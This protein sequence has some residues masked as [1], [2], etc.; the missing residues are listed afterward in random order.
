M[1]NRINAQNVGTSQPSQTDQTPDKSSID[2]PFRASAP[3]LYAVGYCAL[4]VAYRGKVPA[5]ATGVIVNEADREAKAKYYPQLAESF[6][7]GERAPKPLK[8][9]QQT[10]FEELS[11]SGAIRAS[12]SVSMNVGLRLGPQGDDDQTHLFAFDLDTTDPAIIS[13]VA[14]ALDSVDGPIIRK[15]AH[16]GFTQF[17]RIDPAYAAALPAKLRLNDQGIADCLSAGRQTVMPPSLHPS[18]CRYRWTTDD[19]L[20]DYEPGDLPEFT[21]AALDAISEALSAFGEVS[22]TG[23]ARRAGRGAGVYPVTHGP[24]ML[25]NFALRSPEAIAHWIFDLG[26]ANISKGANG[27]WATNTTRGSTTGQPTAQRKQNLLLDDCG[28]HDFGTSRSYSAAGLVAA[29]LNL[30][31]TEAEDWLFDKFADQIAEELPPWEPGAKEEPNPEPES[32]QP[33]NHGWLSLDDAQK[34]ISNTVAKVF[35]AAEEA[36]KQRCEAWAEAGGNIDAYARTEAQTLIRVSVGAGKTHAIVSKAIEAISKNPHFRVLIRMPN[37]KM[38]D[39]LRDDLE[40][41]L[42][43]MER[44]PSADVHVWRGTEAPD[45]RPDLDKVREDQKACA[46]PERLREV[47]K[48]GGSQSAACKDCPF[49][50]TAGSSEKLS[51]YYQQQTSQVITAQIVIVA[52]DVSLGNLPKSILRRELTTEERYAGRIENPDFDL[53]ILDE[54]KPADLVSGADGNSYAPVSSLRADL[55]ALYAEAESGAV[56]DTDK[57]P[58]DAGDYYKKL[59]KLA[60]VLEGA[61]DGDGVSV[62]TLKSQWIY[63]QDLEHLRSFAWKHKAVVSSDM[64]AFLSDQRLSDE[65]LRRAEAINGPVRDIVKILNALIQG[66][67]DAEK[68][69]HFNVPIPQV[70]LASRKVGKEFELCAVTRTRMTLAKQVRNTPVLI[71]DATADGQMLQQWFPNLDL[72]ADVQVEDGE[73]VRRL[74]LIDKRMS[75]TQLVAPKWDDD[76][77][78]PTVEEVKAW[79]SKYVTGRRKPANNDEEAEYKRLKCMERTITARN[80]VARVAALYE[81]LEATQGGSVG[82]VVPKGIRKELQALGVPDDRMMHFGALRGQNDFEGV[83]SLVIVGR[84]S[85]SVRDCERL[86]AVIFG[87]PVDVIAPDDQGRVMFHREKREIKRRG[88]GGVIKEAEWH[89]DERVERVRRSIC[90]SEL[91]Q[92]VGRARGVRRSADNPETEII[93]TNVP[94]DR[95]VDGYLDSDSLK[96]MTGWQGALLAR[97]VWPLEGYGAGVRRRGVL[98]SVPDRLPGFEAALGLTEATDKQI[99]QHINEDKKKPATRDQISRI[100]A[101]MSAGDAFDFHGLQINGADFREK[102]GFAVWAE[103]GGAYLRTENGDTPLYNLNNGVS[104]DSTAELRNGRHDKVD[105]CLDEL[106]LITTSMTHASAIAPH[107]WPSAKSAERHVSGLEPGQGEIRITYRW[108]TKRKVN[109]QAIVRAETH[110]QAQQIILAAMPGAEIV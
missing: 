41:A 29:A 22:E 15:A 100:D 46:M 72:A 39:Q 18:G 4:P 86:A 17:F 53:I 90:E 50:P 93:L 108:G 1:T 96:A 80:N 62:E 23:S 88:G 43:Q 37:H 40:T 11:Q 73:G 101:A 109:A 71:M 79:R 65:L 104:Q 78:E 33:V 63:K 64:L 2:S 103:R 27:Y 81:L 82:L 60:G 44:N 21:K 61:K 74:Q 34:E 110:E 16:K 14:E 77:P 28:I 94:L 12:W 32:P 31:Y 70:E 83:D 87:E 97:G 99:D 47:R 66:F 13:A 91:I 26:L 20:T 51:C 67:E 68:H 3:A 95:P 10:S 9:W 76:N 54:T 59:D 106:G 107:I 19:I 58:F 69:K 7:V 75:Y 49:K 38:A 52:G 30:E 55:V 102:E 98:R 35:D 57:L 24:S 42:I 6:V 105:R 48:A 84:Q 25:D 89:P 36:R 85:P 8:G 45:P 5:V 56:V 92:A